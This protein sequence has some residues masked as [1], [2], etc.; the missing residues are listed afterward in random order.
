MR[1]NIVLLLVFGFMLGC[2]LKESRIAH[3]SSS[4][5]MQVDSAL[6][7]AKNVQTLTHDFGVLV[8]PITGAVQC[9]FEIHNDSNTVWNLKQIVNT[10]SCTVAD[11]TSPTIEPGKTEKNLI[12]YQPI[13]EGSFDD[14]RQSLV[15]FNEE[16]APLFLLIVSSKVREPM[17]IEPKI[18]SWMQVGEDQTRQGHFEI[19]NFSDKNW[20]NITIQKKPDWLTVDSQNVVPPEHK[21]PMR[22]FWMAN[23]AINTAGLRPGEYRDEIMI[24]TD[25][26]EFAAKVPVVLQIRSVATAI[27]AQ[28][29]F[30][31]VKQGETV[32]RTTKIVFSPYSVPKDKS[33]IHIKH[34][35]GTIL[36]FDWLTTTG[37]SWELQ[38]SLTFEKGG[39]PD[40]PVVEMTF[41]DPKM[42]KLIL[43]I[44]VMIL[45]ETK[46]E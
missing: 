29:F 24:Q 43:P 26:S 19:Q 46:N 40:E 11:I 16:S 13:G 31:D 33:E 5:T 36:L 20:K 35:L 27:P 9:K 23:V 4:D 10:C 17:T 14:T 38:A 32:T 18:L 28:F 22:Q 21:T 1:I 8:A 7:Q 6:E 44:Y 39:L 42:P 41:S 12:T 30:G 3:I 25:N 45:S 2:Q 34:N 15:R 37:N